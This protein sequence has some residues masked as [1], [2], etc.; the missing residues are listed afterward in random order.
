MKK[1]VVLLA[2]LPL[3]FSCKMQKGAVSS[4]NGNDLTGWMMLPGKVPGF[5]VSE[6]NLVT[7]PPNSSDLFTKARYGNYL[8]KF[9]YLLSE[10]GNSGV[11]I[12][13]DP[14]DPWGTG[15][16]VQLLAP[17]TPY[18]DDLHCTGSLYGYVPV[19]N[20][21]DETTGIWHEMEIK[22]DRSIITVSVDGV[23]TTIANTDTV[24]GMEKKQIEGAI[25]FQS[26]HGNE[27]EY[28][29]FRNISIHNFDLEPEYV[30][31]GFHEKDVRFREQ[32]YRSARSIGVPM[33][34]HLAAMMSEEDIIAYAGAK[35][36][37]FDLSAEASSPDT[38]KHLRNN[39]IKALKSCSKRS[40]SKDTSD[41]LH[42]LLA[43]LSSD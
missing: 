36:I 41:Y 20:R 1:T 35:K 7:T 38:P 2:L 33:I 43:M 8:F 14:E 27:G 34:E 31:R 22:C 30:A 32:A 9:E 29:K 39:T 37:L 13:C 21:P 24:K 25:G 15:V 3:L 18:R 17:W 16:E 19:H 6:G 28:A 12:R 42:R 5:E 4:L 40:D 11:L 10:V 26:N 23:V